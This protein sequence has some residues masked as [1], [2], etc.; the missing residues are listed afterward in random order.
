MISFSL[1]I[2]LGDDLSFACVR[3]SFGAALALARVRQC[4]RGE[5]AAM[6]GARSVLR[7]WLRAICVVFST[8]E[9]SQVNIS[10]PSRARFFRR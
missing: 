4:V 8:I 1:E 6:R 10:V 7:R 2:I 5:G 9:I 3:A